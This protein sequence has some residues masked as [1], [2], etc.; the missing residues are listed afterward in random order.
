MQLTIAPAMTDPLMS[1]IL[2]IVTGMMVN[3]FAMDDIHVINLHIYIP[4]FFGVF[5]VVE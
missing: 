5:G 2:V 1:N 4:R 3:A